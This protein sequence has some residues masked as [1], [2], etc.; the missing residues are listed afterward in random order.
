M[1][2][3]QVLPSRVGL[4]PF[5]VHKPSQVLPELLLAWL[6]PVHLDQTC[7][8]PLSRCRVGHNQR[9]CQPASAS[10]HPTLP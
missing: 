7:S 3:Q 6:P 10:A 5:P 1:M 8:C 9:S 2:A 4:R